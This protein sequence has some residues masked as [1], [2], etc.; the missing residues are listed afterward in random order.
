MCATADYLYLSAAVI[1]VCAAKATGARGSAA[2]CVR[3][4]RDGS[5]VQALRVRPQCGW[6]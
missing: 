5:R 3:P 6:C 4:G 1:I 2:G